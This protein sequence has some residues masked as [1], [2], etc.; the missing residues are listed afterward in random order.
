[1]PNVPPLIGLDLLEPARLAERLEH[2]PELRETLFTAGELA[3]AD[4]QPDPMLHLAARFCAKE[5]IV[6]ALGINGWDPLEVEITGGGEQTGLCLRGDAARRADELGVDMRI[7]MSH[8]QAIAGAV[9][10][11]VPRP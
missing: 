10:Q 9:A 1:M 7:S 8:V 4:A 11:A 3:Y 5:A 6:K 2:R